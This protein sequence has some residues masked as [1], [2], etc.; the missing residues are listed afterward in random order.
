M[1]KPEHYNRRSKSAKIRR[2]KELKTAKVEVRLT[3]VEK[4]ELE[5]YS[6][7]SHFS[8]VSAWLRFL[9]KNEI[10]RMKRSRNDEPKSSRKQED[11]GQ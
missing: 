10:E 1:T 4:V 3:E 7:L 5:K 8:S 6:N 9:A 11:D 2:M